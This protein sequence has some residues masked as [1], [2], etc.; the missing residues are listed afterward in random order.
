MVSKYKNS[1]NQNSE[2][3][4]QYTQFKFNNLEEEVGSPDEFK[5]AH[6]KIF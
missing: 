2:T 4:K 3:K 6:L 1:T 5:Q